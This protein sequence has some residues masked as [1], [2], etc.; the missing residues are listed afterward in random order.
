MPPKPLLA[1]TWPRRVS[2][3]EFATAFVTYLRRF[4]QSVTTLA[5][6][7]G[8]RE[9]KQSLAIQ[10]RLRLV[11]KRLAYLERIIDNAA[12]A[13]TDEEPWPEPDSH[14]MH[15]VL[16]PQEHSGERQMQRLE[17]QVE[18]LHRQL[19]SLQSRGWLRI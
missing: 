7:E 11:E 15:P 14:S 12:P 3:A 18:I 16:V 8:E 13:G 10:S 17:R 5:S 2:F 4:A 9:W 19:R 1:E 6:L